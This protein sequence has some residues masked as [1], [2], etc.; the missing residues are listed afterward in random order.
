MATAD[1]NVTVVLD[2]VD[3]ATGAV[4]GHYTA[5]GKTQDLEDVVTDAVEAFSEGECHAPIPTRCPRINGQRLACV[6]SLS[7]GGGGTVSQRIDGGSCPDPNGYSRAAAS[8]RWGYDFKG[9]HVLGPGAS[10]RATYAAVR[11]A[12]A[13]DAQCT[14]NSEHCQGG[15]VVESGLGPWSSG[16]GSRPGRWRLKIPVL[17]AVNHPC[18]TSAIDDPAVRESATL[19]VTLRG[20]PKR[21]RR[22]VK[23]VPFAMRRSLGCG[24]GC[25][26]SYDL[27]GIVVIRGE[28]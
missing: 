9:P 4:V 13:V 8:L 17:A 21:Q 19:T 14:T 22:R 7:E 3:L 28:W 26:D 5:E 20:N 15:M 6:T 10:G 1:G 12:Y 16:D 18:S 11:G 24:A 25:K 23:V 27:N 2:V